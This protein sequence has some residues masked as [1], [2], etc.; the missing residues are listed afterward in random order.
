LTEF[1]LA[2]LAGNVAFLSGPW[3]RSL[4]A[5]RAENQPAG[6]VLFDGAC[7]YCRRSVALIVAADP[8]RVVE[9]IDLTAI[10][11]KTIH[12]DL[13]AE[14][15]M[16]AMHLVRRDGRID[17]GYDAVVRLGRWLPLFW[18]L[19]LLG[20]TPGVAPLGRRIYNRIAASR[21][22][23]SPCTDE[24]CA[25]PSWTEVRSSAPAR[26]KAPR[27]RPAGESSR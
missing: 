12:P 11:V 16:R 10:D 7:P 18:P 6:R 23:E 27:E 9:P 3:L 4:V 25:L 5:G 24:T 8:E 26:R 15:C 13:K 22:R 21:P 1:A 19:G 14:E 20:S 2:M 17:F